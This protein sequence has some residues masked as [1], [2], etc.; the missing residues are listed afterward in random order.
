MDN[1]S[2]D[3]SV[4]VARSFKDDHIKIF[5]NPYNVGFAPNLDRAAAKAQN[6]FIIML[7]SDDLMRPTALEEYAKVITLSNADA[8][9][10]L[11]ASSVEI[12]DSQ[13][14]FVEQRDRVSYYITQPDA[15]LSAVFGDPAIEAFHGLA[16]FK[17]T[18]PY[19]STP[20]HFCSML[21]S[22]AL[23]EKVG[24]YSSI[25]PIGPDAH[26]AYKILLQDAKV[27]YINKPLFAY[28]IHQAN[29]AHQ[30]RANI[31]L[32]INVYFFTLQYSD[33]ELK[34]TGVERQEIIHF[35]VDDTCLTG[36]FHEL[37][38][39]S[40]YQAFRYLMFAFA[41][42]PGMALKN[43]KTYALAALFCLG[44]LGAGLA[45]LIYRMHEKS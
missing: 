35:L 40:S 11:I 45:R 43:P 23:Y 7:S 19:M 9:R 39:G 25:H 10:T 8:E 34:R 5:C 37:R 22:K 44:Y 21:F 27:V 36:G 28:R 4:E 3:K 20:G 15:T 12:I 13:G 42:A 18:Y 41:S 30:A 38:R 17:D 26:L 24:G 14:T 33:E 29:Q 16:V 2:T 31:N 1:A 32:P 6:P